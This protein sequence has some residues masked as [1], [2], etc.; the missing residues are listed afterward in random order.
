M[1]E[2]LPRGSRGL[3]HRAF[4]AL[5]LPTDRCSVA[6]LQRRSANPNNVHLGAAA[7]KHRADWPV[8]GM[9]YRLSGKQPY[10]LIK[11]VVNDD[12]KTTVSSAA[13]MLFM[14]KFKVLLTY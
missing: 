2:H 12:V 6:L 11:D 3:S 1:D 10:P 14:K 5:T 7:L 8:D 13:S 4:S 9:S